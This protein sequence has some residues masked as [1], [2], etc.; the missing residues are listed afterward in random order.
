M[1]VELIHNFSCYIGLSW[2]TKFHG[3]MMPTT[4]KTTKIG[5]KLNKT[6]LKVASFIIICGFE[7]EPGPN[8]NVELAVIF[9]IAEFHKLG[10]LNIL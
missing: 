6:L 1:V 5:I 2:S 3:L 10:N 4:K 9:E 8:I 7:T